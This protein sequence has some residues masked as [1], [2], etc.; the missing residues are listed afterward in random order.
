MYYIEGRKYS[1]IRISFFFSSILGDCSRCF[2]GRVHV[3][4]KAKC[5]RQLFCKH[6]KCEKNCGDPC[7]L[8][9]ERCAWECPHHKCTKLCGELCDRPRCHEPCT[10]LL[11]CQHPCIGLCGEMC[12]KK[13]RECHKDEVTEIY[14]G[15]EDEPDARFVEL[16]DCGHVFEVE[17]MDQWMDQAETTSDG[18]P[19]DVQFKLCPKCRVPIRTSLRYGNIIKNILADFGRIKQKILLDERSGERDLEVGRLKSRLQEIDQFPKDR[20]SMMLN[21]KNLTDDQINVIENQISFLSFL[22]TL[23]VDA[24]YFE[25]L[26][27]ETKEDLESK[28]EQLRKRV[29]EF[30][31]RFSDQERE[32]LNEEM[33]RTQLLIDFRMLKIRLDIQGVQLGGSDTA[34][35][36]FVRE[37][38]DSGRVIG[39]QIKCVKIRI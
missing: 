12:P 38:L 21:R 32:E 19:V 33:R 36:F 10:K 24:G 26:P 30:R 31:V 14:F 4:C 11:P 17:A 3:P 29:M 22:Q 25:E 16:A 34:E 1:Q 8:C 23:K 27:K 9:N 6:N 13:C 18:K 35:I 20:I 5:D 39:K 2:R 37:A 7:D 28:V 15:T